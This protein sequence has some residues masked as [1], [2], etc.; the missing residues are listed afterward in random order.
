MQWMSKMWLEKGRLLL[1]REGRL[2]SEDRAEGVVGLGPFPHHPQCAAVAEA[3]LVGVDKG[4]RCRY[5]GQGAP[6][7]G[8][9]GFGP[10]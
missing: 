7:Q 10:E 8:R 9:S 2:L 5:L 4:A 6:G 3:G 1:P